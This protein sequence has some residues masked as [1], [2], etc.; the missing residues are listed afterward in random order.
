MK[1]IFGIL[2]CML[3][4]IPVVSMA[5]AQNTKTNIMSPQN[6]RTIVDVEI[7]DYYYSPT[8]LTIAVGDTVKW[9]NMGP[10][11]HSSTSDT[12]IWDSG[13]LGVGQSFSFTF[14]TAGTYPY[15]CSLHPFMHGSVIVTSGN[16]P[17]NIP[18]QPTGPTLLNVLQ[19][20]SYSTSTT[21]PEGDQVQY[22]FDWD[23][24]GA[25][26]YSSW[27]SLVPS[28]QSVNISHAWS[29]T[30]TYV[31]EAQA[32]DS[33]GGIS[34]WSTGLTVMVSI[35]GNQPPNTPS[36][37]G[38][39]SGTAG[40]QYPYSAVTS[41]PENDNI[42][43]YFDWGDGTNTGWTAYVASGTSTS[44][45]HSWMMKGTY[46]IKVK[47]KD[48][49]NL[50]SAYATLQVTMPKSLSINSL[51]QRFIDQYPNTIQILRHLLGI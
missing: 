12:S 13:L 34:G 42:A 1:K 6:T 27:S 43:Y 11:P 17:P 44:E 22:R 14:N 19:S 8:P 33:N 37:S 39:T 51:F 40:T 16:L 23:A 21:D 48:I 29:A 4:M 26:D 5:T 31:V 47:A 30:G 32:Q 15:H 49:N 3:M 7:H 9:T 46:T 38:P 50:E 24:A 41:D 10:A 35:G 20:G 2:I 36:I 45:S 25:H 18:S 28:G